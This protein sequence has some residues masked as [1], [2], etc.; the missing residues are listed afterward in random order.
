LK[1]AERLLHE[2]RVEKLPLSTRRQG[3]GLIN[4]E[5]YYE[6]HAIPKATK[7]AK[8]RLAVGAQWGA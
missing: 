1:D 8:G 6:D 5:R 7:D 2:Y 3:G 4:T